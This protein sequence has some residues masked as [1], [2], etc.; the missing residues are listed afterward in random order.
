MFMNENPTIFPRIQIVAKTD[1]IENEERSV[2]RVRN[3]VRTHSEND[4]IEPPA[5]IARCTHLD[6]YVDRGAANVDESTLQI[7]NR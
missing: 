5:T 2:Y 6:V 7:I 1:D 3:R 4:L